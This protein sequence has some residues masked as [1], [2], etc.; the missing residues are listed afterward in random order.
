MNKYIKNAIQPQLEKAFHNHFKLIL[1]MVFCRIVHQSPIKNI[2]FH[3][4]G[5]C[6]NEMLDTVIPTEK[7]ISQGLKEFGIMITAMVTYTKAFVQHEN[8]IL[9]DATDLACHLSNVSLASKDYNSKMDFELQFTLLYVYSATNHSPYFFRLLP[10]NIREVSALKN[11]LEEAVITD[12]TFKADKGFY[13]ENNINALENKRL[14][15]IIPL[16]RKQTN[17]L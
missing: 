7:S 4:S 14:K 10:G 13:S 11:T 16:R 17:K 15:Y 6:F 5:Y 8:C 1:L 12:T 3:L 9:V 2:P